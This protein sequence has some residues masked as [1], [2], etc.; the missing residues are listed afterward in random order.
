MG[1]LPFIFKWSSNW[2]E[3]ERANWRRI[4][5][6]S[7][8]L[9][10]AFAFAP[11][12]FLAL[13]GITAYALMKD[14][15]FVDR[16]FK[17]PLLIERLKRRATVVSIALLMNIP[18]SL[19][20]LIH[21]HR[22]FLDSGYLTSAGGPNY[23]IFGNPGG[24]GALPWWNISPLL[25]ILVIA[26][27]SVTKARFFAEI[28]LVFLLTATFFSSVS[29]RGNG[30]S[31]PE[32][33]YPGV[34]LAIATILA[35]ISGVIML[36]QLR[37]TLIQTHVNF[38]HYAAALLLAASGI[39]GITTIGWIATQGAVSPVQ[40]GA[41]EVLPAFLAIEKDA[42]TV[43][44]RVQS[45]DDFALNFYVARG[46]DVTLG[47]PDVAP[48]E[49]QPISEAV[50]NIADGSGL[51]SSKTLASHGI[52]YV[53]FKSPINPSIVRTIDGLGGFTRASSTSAGVSW[54]VV[55]SA[56]ELVFTPTSGASQVLVRNE[57]SGM[58][59]VPSLGIVT[60]T[61]NFSRGWQLSQ[62]GKRLARSKSALD[63]P[64]FSITEPGD[65]ELFYDGTLR[66]GW[67]SLQI[68][69]LV[70]VITLSLPGGRRRR[71]ISEKEL[72]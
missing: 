27:F 10:F 41:S 22:F 69:V 66:R 21:P 61:E 7:A 52:K 58:Y 42:K 65:V 72:A 51:A 36:D 15:F 17:A 9:G 55:G 40:S 24:P 71:E 3:I 19:E 48:Y 60:L 29:L 45:K 50:R 18:W 13:L 31:A 30:S 43:V 38:R 62:D 57:Q 47:Q 46:G 26:L 59:S 32:L 1:L 39:Y 53:F 28:G 67:L 63:L 6:V 20:L 44:L 11:Q 8:A 64:V 70:T 68:V 14:Y 35:I 5:Q 37:E 54:K 16:D 23:A 4:F 34:F 56:G 2:Y 33:I 12:L 49:S 25:F